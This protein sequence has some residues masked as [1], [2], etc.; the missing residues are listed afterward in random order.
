MNQAAQKPLR[1]IHCFRSPVGGI[2][3][4]VRDLAEHHS[5]AGHE[6]GILCDSTT[7]GSLE[8]SYFDSIRPFLS[9]GLTRIPIR[10]SIGPSDVNAL[11]NCYRE[12]KSLQPDVL[13][14]H[15]AKGG[16]L[17][18]IIGSVL[19]VN[20]YRVARFYSP[21]GGSM[22]FLKN[23]L[24]GRGVFFLERVLEWGTDG[25]VFVSQ[26]ESQVYS[27]KIGVPKTSSTVVYNGI[28][29]SEFEKVAVRSDAADFLYIGMMRDLKG[30]DIFIEAF[31]KTER[32]IGRPLSA[33][34][35][36]D[37]PDVDKYLTMI[38]QLGLL[39]RVNLIAAMKPKVAFSY[40]PTV[41]VPSRA[42]AMPYI[43]IEALGA[44]RSVIAARVGGIPEVLGG[45]S[46]ALAIPDNSD[47]LARIMA[48]AVSV[49]NWGSTTMPNYNDI[50]S[51]FS[52]THMAS[53]ILELYSKSL[54][55]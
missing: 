8:D 50:K 52:S 13:H 42:E 20:K 6:V 29:E 35:V 5:N 24:K 46:P 16:A 48:D 12:I 53:Q 26:Q 9:L 39:R 33:V 22:H 25:L 41:V 27:K 32:L 40:A 2:F 19:R 1:I 43:V 54:A 37:G 55:R 36:G 21:H 23:S 31:A 15:G 30:P 47:D 38:E 28:R 3:R 4:H 45:N 10:R 11:I 34:M 14:G 51:N 18:R 49:A 17:A 7:G 44:G